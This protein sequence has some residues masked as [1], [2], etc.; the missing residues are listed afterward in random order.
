[1]AMIAT[2]TIAAKA[3]VGARV[4]LAVDD[5]VELPPAAHPTKQGRCSGGRRQPPREADAA[6]GAWSAALSVAPLGSLRHTPLQSRFLERDQPV[7]LP[8]IDQKRLRAGFTSEVQRAA[9]LA[10]EAC[11]LS[12]GKR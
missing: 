10:V 3:V 7:T 2:G 4:D 5:V 1:M 12:L 8:Q 11:N 9:L 6:R